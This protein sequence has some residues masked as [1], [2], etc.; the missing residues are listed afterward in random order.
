MSWDCLRQ[1]VESKN[2]PR[3]VRQWPIE[4]NNDT[5]CLAFALGLDYADVH[6]E[7]FGLPT[8]L[9]LKTYL[10][11]ICENVGISYRE[12]NSCEEAKEDEMIIKGYE[13]IRCLDNRKGFHVIR[14]EL[15]K[16]WVHKE[17]W[18]NMPCEITNWKNFNFFYPEETRSCLI[19]IKEKPL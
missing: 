19:A 8:C 14:R 4:L 3:S 18:E 13:F 15:D 1:C 7:Y 2:W 11:R 5:N 12:I 10:K 16:T 9:D 17:G 6:R